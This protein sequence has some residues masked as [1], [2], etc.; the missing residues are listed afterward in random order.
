MKHM[1]VIWQTLS[2]IEA[3]GPQVLPR[4]QLPICCAESQSSSAMP[5]SSHKLQTEP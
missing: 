2:S 5:I 3:Y 4:K 1:A